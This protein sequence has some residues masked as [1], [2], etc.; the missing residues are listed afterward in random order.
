MTELPPDV[1]AACQRLRQGDIVRGVPVVEMVDLSRPLGAAA[2]K[3]RETRLAAGADLGVMPVK[4]N[5]DYACI[6]SQTCDVVQPSKHS[7]VVASVVPHGDPADP[8]V[9][10]VKR[11]EKRQR[12]IDSIK[13]GRKPHLIHF[14]LESDDLGAGGY[15]DLRALTTVQKPVLAEA[16]ADRFLVAGE[17]SRAFAFRCGHLRPSGRS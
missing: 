13:S 3:A 2:T 15:V 10:S 11:L 9:T 8:A 1:Q 14:D 12:A 17:A 16:A 5:S 6:V 7:V 4:V